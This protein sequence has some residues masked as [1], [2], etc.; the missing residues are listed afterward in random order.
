MDGWEENLYTLSMRVD[1]LNG[2]RALQAVLSKGG[3]RPAAKQLGVTPAAVGHQIRNLEAY[4]GVELLERHPNGSKPTSIAQQVAND[5]SRHM[6]GLADV[7]AR[8][9]PAETPH[10]V[11][12]SVLPSFAEGWLSGHLA[13]LFSQL[14]G[15]DLRLD[16]SRN[17]AKLTDGAHDFAIRYAREPSSDLN[18]ELLLEDY[19]APVCTADFAKRY[20]LSTERNSLAGVPIAEIDFDEIESTGAVP[21]LIDWCHQ[22]DANPPQLDSGQVI[23]SYAAGVKMAR[24]GLVVFLAGLHD[25]IDELE[26]GDVWLPFG[27]DQVLLNEHKFWLVWRKD[28]RLSG[29]Q[30]DFINWISERAAIDRRRIGSLVL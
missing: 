12:V 13:T 2:L 24:S 4:L 9:R 3:L 17:I 26:T 6:E 18:S 22:F 25:I 15:I 10:R 11:S 20:M 19:C 14:P 7:M 16:A 29:V 27:S 28:K 8:L 30:K 21:S 5:L 1:H 23:L